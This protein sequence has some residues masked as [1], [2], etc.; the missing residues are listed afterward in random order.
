MYFYCRDNGIEMAS[1][2]SNRNGLS[3]VNTLIDSIQICNENSKC[4]Y[5]RYIFF[6]YLFDPH[7]HVQLNVHWIGTNYKFSRTEE[8]V[9]SISICKKSP[10]ILM[11]FEFQSRKL[12]TLLLCE[13]F[14]HV[15]AG[16]LCLP[17]LHSFRIVSLKRTYL[18]GKPIDQRENGRINGRDIEVHMLA[19]AML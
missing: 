3:S 7:H 1:R 19:Y 18:T 10:S 2:S 15:F 9:H 5:L 8:N 16:L 12:L 11:P 17:F 13:F 4:V 14:V 6:I